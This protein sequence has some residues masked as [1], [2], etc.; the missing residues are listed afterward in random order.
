LRQ[1]V[2]LSLIS[3]V[4]AILVE[5]FPSNQPGEA[6]AELVV[7]ERFTIYG[8]SG[9]SVKSTHIESNGDAELL[10]EWSARSLAP[11]RP[12]YTVSVPT[13]NRL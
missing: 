1:H 11:L 7:H 8:D 2:V 10:V 13:T 4:H 9:T 12:M 6:F 3:R 5:E